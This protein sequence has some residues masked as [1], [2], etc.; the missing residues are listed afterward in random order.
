MLLLTMASAMVAPTSPVP[1]PP[2][3]V[4]RLPTFDVPVPIASLD[5]EVWQSARRVNLPAAYRTYLIRFP[6]GQHA[7]AAREALNL[8][9][10]DAA[11]QPSAATSPGAFPASN[12]LGLRRA[13]GEMGADEEERL[14]R[15]VHSNRVGDYQAY[16]TAHPNGACSAPV[17]GTLA[18][19]AARRAGLVL[20]PRFGPLAPHRLRGSITAD[21]Y[22]SAALRAG[23]EGD[24]LAEW[25]VAEDGFP[26][27]CR[28]AV[29]S[30]S[31]ILDEATCRLVIR[32]MRYDPAR[33]F[34]GRPVRGSDQARVRW[35]IED[36]APMPEPAAPGR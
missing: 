22:P 4:R 30:G 16:L 9:G 28:I 27:S 3:V 20:I 36:P 7:A 12:C 35:Q 31:R 23:E 21:D 13:E 17:A 6:A 8:T 18:M 32:G 25:E 33:E 34:S 10:T 26:E 1:P 29:S 14:A 24:V 15:A 5:E 2:R 11:A 19:R